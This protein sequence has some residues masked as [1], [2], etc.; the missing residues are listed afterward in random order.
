M[1]AVLVKLPKQGRG[2]DVRNAPFSPVP[3]TA[4][5]ANAHPLVRTDGPDWDSMDAQ[6][7]AD[8]RAICDGGCGDC[9]EFRAWGECSKCG[10][11]TEAL[12]SD[13]LSMCCGSRVILGRAA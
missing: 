12:G 9:D 1:T 5:L 10:G 3:A 7:Q 2:G 4:H 6:D 11:V 8:H 13:E